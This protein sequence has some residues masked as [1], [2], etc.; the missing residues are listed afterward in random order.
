MSLALAAEPGLT[1][2]VLE[3]GCR[4]ATLDHDAPAIVEGSTPFVR[5]V[6]GP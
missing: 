4:V 5:R 1:G 3:N 2:R 6:T